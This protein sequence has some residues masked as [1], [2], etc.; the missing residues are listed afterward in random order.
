MLK[1]PLPRDD[2]DRQNQ[3]FTEN[4]LERF[5][6]EKR[7]NCKCKEDLEDCIQNAA[8]SVQKS[9]TWDSLEPQ[10][11]LPYFRTVLLHKIYDLN[12]KNKHVDTVISIDDDKFR[13]DS[14]V[15]LSHSTEQLWTTKIDSDQLLRTL[16]K[17]IHLKLGEQVELLD[18]LEKRILQKDL[19][20][21]INKSPSTISKV[22]REIIDKIKDWFANK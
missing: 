15:Q 3:F 18:F 21:K 8:I 10:L 5:L 19:A 7:R 9:E 1:Y 12:P 13:L 22:K 2:L 4:Y 20:K 11:K 17:I 6:K 14:C 16:E